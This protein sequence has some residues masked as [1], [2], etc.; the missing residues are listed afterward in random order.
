[1]IAQTNTIISEV[2]R[3]LPAFSEAEEIT[4][5]KKALHDVL[6]VPLKTNDYTESVETVEIIY[7]L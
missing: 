5:E 1:M 6:D 3:P 7:G 2:L 4:V